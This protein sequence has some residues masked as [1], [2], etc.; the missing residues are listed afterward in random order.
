MSAATAMLVGTALANVAANWATNRQNS[1]N[2]MKINDANIGMQLAY[3]ADQVEVARMNNQTSIDLAN[4]A[5]Q[6]EVKD[7][8]DAGLNPILSATGG[9]GAAMPSLSTPNGGSAELQAYRAENPLRELG[10]SA[11]EIGR[12]MTA[13]FDAQTEQA[14]A[15]ADYTKYMAEQA[16]YDAANARRDSALHATKSK[17]ELDAY[18]TLQDD[19]VAF[20]ADGNLVVKASAG[21]AVPMSPEIVQ[22]V[23][24][25]IKADIHNKRWADVQRWLQI[26][27]GAANSASGA[28]L[29]SAR[30]IKMFK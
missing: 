30:V 22:A 25:G 7:L 29:N 27:S 20:D 14:E 12:M 4:T 28:G 6:R 1:I 17:L 16:K 24:A 5:H 10:T 11:R 3:N 13:Q 2:Q 23:A 9:N 18:K 26:L 8:R 21:G 19:S 15:Q